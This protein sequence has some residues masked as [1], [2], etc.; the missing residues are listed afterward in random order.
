MGK[1]ESLPPL[2]CPKGKGPDR[3]CKYGKVAGEPVC[4]GCL[5]PDQQAKRLKQEV[6]DKLKK[7]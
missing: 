6:E 4:F 7:K 3:V 5:T 2:E 1:I